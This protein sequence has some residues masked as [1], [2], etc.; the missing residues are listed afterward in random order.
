MGH[1]LLG[2]AQF[3]GQVGLGQAE[4]LAVFGDPAPEPLVEVEG[5]A[6]TT[7]FSYR[8]L[9]ESEQRAWTYSLRNVTRFGN[10]PSEVAEIERAANYYN[11]QNYED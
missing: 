11:T 10:T 2:D 6:G 8:G 1:R 7:D 9:W 3:L 5:H 4:R